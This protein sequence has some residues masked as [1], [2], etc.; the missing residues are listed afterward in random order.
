[1]LRV[2]HS[3][4]LLEAIHHHVANNNSFA[5]Q[6]ITQPEEGQQGLRATIWETQSEEF[7]NEIISNL[8]SFRLMSC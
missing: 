7:F 2:T 4:K 6:G 8:D 5:D 3:S 1:M